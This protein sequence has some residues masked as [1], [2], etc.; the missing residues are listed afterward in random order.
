MTPEYDLRKRKNSKGRAKT[1]RPRNS[2]LDE[3]LDLK[4]SVPEKKIEEKKVEKR[5]KQPPKKKTKDSSQRSISE[6]GDQYGYYHRPRYEDDEDEYVP[7][8]KNRQVSKKTF[9][10]DYDHEPRGYGKPP[11]RG[12]PTR[13][14]RGG[15][16]GGHSLE[17]FRAPPPGYY[18]PPPGPPPGYFEQR[19]GNGFPKRQDFEK[20]E[21]P[22]FYSG[23]RQFRMDKMR[24]QPIE[25][26]YY[27]EEKAKRD[28]RN[29]P[30]QK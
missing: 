22:G 14:G 19:S 30:Q 6:E 15:S 29:R 21:R 18:R 9:D 28:F 5:E 20:P 12:Y 4:K 24:D 27:P 17:Q 11:A 7:Y 13:G 10:S 3:D 8:S 26:K 25:G 1:I 23:N 16:R 2:T